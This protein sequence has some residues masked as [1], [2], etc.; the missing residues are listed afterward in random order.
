M[1]RIVAPSNVRL[2]PVAET[3]HDWLIELHNDPQV[4][5]NLTDPRPITLASHMTWWSSV[6]D[7]PKHRR[8][9]FTIN[10][11]RAGLAKIS[12]I[13][14]TNSNCLLGGDINIEH[15]GKGHA[16][17][18]WALMLDVVFFGL[19]LNRAGLTTA[20]YN[21]IGQRVYRGLG[22]K[23]EGRLIKHLCRDG[24]FHDQ[25]C[26]YMLRDDWVTHE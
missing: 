20:E 14:V 7:S 23:E 16:R 11:A 4:L 26:M 17:H 9:V 13:D 18:M 22:F 8:Y 3:D 15:R 12:D 6:K 21:T 1:S 24:I 2:R 25:L 19:G 5:H 10:D